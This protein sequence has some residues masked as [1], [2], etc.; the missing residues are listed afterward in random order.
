MIG[1]EIQDDLNA[2][3][4]YDEKFNNAIVRH[5]LDLKY[6]AIFRNPNPI[7][8]TFHDMKKFNF[9]NPVIGK[10]ASQ[11]CTSKLPDY[12][13]TKKL[14][15]QGKI[16]KLQLRLDALKYGINKDD[17]NDRGGGGRGGD[18]GMP[19][20]PPPWN[21]QQEMDDIV[22]RLDFLRG[23]TC[24]VSPDNTPQQKSKIIA[25]KN[26]EKFQIGK[27]EKEKVK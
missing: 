3:V 15:E 21:P 11:V 10:L 6:E 1:N 4:D 22:R 13:L 20:P 14:L 24:D 27:L 25:R 17:D 12:E 9:V 26:Q 19:S 2:I 23:N 18:D 7:N 16:D 8:V 5:P